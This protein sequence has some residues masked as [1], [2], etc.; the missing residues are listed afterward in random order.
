MYFCTD[1]EFNSKSVYK[2][3]IAM[4]NRTLTPELVRLSNAFPVVILTGPRQSGKTTL[5]KMAFPGYRYVNLE[6][7]D[8][9]ELILANPLDFLRDNASGMILDEVQRYPELFSYIQ[10]AVDED[11]S[12]RYILSGSNNF[13]LM[14]TIT[15]SLAG[16][17]AMLTLL[18]LSIGEL[19]PSLNADELML[20]GFYPAV[21]GDGRLPHDVYSGY[22]LTYIERDLRQLINVKDLNLFR[23]FVKL[24]ASRVSCEFNASHISND[25]GIDIKTVQSWLGILTT[26]YIAFLLPPYYRN[27]GKRI[28]KANK[29]YFY[30]TGLVAYLLGLENPEQIATHPLRGALFENMVVSEFH[31]RCFNQGSSPNLYYYRDSSQKE[32]DL[33][34]ETIY[35]QLNAY[36]IK[37]ARR[38]STQFA[39]GIDYFSKL[40]GNKV[41][42]G[43]VL[44]DGTDTVTV[45]NITCTNWQNALL[46]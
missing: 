28:I 21:W 14:A 2:Y 40:Y 33:V 41:K 5:C 12:L 26:S 44:Y 42:S 25:L 13:T 18:P 10:V 16:R 38:Y 31:K 1:L 24:M 19:R 3:S 39:A 17:A 37:S 34:E 23:Q 6:N 46:D 30:D 4:I 9:L 27:I 15:Q 32:V 20:R 36:E 29:L 45:N 7:P 43:T 35:D 8:T 11:K 22:Y